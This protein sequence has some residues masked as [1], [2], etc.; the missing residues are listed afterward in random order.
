LCTFLIYTATGTDVKIVATVPTVIVV[1][2]AVTVSAILIIR[3]CRLRRT[4]NDK[5]NIVEVSQ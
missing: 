2:I 5:E 3:Y 1:L 4:Q